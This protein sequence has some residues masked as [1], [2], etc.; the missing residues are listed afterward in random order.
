MAASSNGNMEVVRALLAAKADANAK[1]ADGTTALMITSRANELNVLQAL[2]AAKADVNA[3]TPNG[4]T[5]L[6]LASVNGHLEVVRALLAAKAEANAK[7]AD[8]ETAMSLATLRG[9]AEIVQLLKGAQ[10]AGQGTPSG[11]TQKI[12]SIDLST[13]AK[14][15][16]YLAEEI[17]REFPGA[18]DPKV[19]FLPANPEDKF[20]TTLGNYLT[21]KG[22]WIT[23]PDGKMFFPSSQVF[24]DAEAIKQL[25]AVRALMNYPS[26]SGNEFLTKLTTH[27]NAVVR[28]SAALALE[29]RAYHEADALIKLLDDPNSDVRLAAIL[30]LGPKST[31]MTHHNS[32]YWSLDGFYHK[33]HPNPKIY[34]KLQRFLNSANISERIAV[35]NTL[36]YVCDQRAI[37]SL[38][39]LLDD[40]NKTVRREADSSLDALLAV[41]HLHHNLR[42]IS[43]LA[44]TTLA[45]LTEY[46]ARHA[47]TGDADAKVVLAEIEKRARR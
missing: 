10:L 30:A 5:A 14:R 38:I 13:E 27:P 3:K 32:P 26:D 1:M 23:T 29:D 35:A 2:L 45:K 6:M 44:A 11:A 42:I 15:I 17:D 16:N 31:P 22:R 39:S 18:R 9:F 8:G 20:D 36:A 19:P 25:S 43:D 12:S 28:M 47:Q 37:P 21:V 41:N 33:F 46:V 4:A 34:P 40:E 24:G 7:A